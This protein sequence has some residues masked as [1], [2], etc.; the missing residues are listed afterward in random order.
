[1]RLPL[2]PFTVTVHLPSVNSPLFES[3]TKNL[4]SKF[5]YDT[6]KDNFGDK[7]K[8]PHFFGTAFIEYNFSFF[9]I[10]KFLG[11]FVEKFEET[12][13]VQGAMDKRDLYVN[14]LGARFGKG[15]RNNGSLLPSEF[16]KKYAYD[17]K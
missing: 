4:P 17:K 8:L 1:L 12:F 9:N 10:S 3:K 11:I 16:L 6:P 2:V 7:D 5:F 14:R 13:Y 15:L